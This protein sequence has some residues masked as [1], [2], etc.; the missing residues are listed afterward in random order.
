[1][2]VRDTQGRVLRFNYLD[3]K[4]AQK[5]DRFRGLQSID[6][7]VGRF[8]Y[9]YGSAMPKGATIDPIH[10]LATLVKVSLPTHYD[11]NQPAHPYANRG[12][13]SSSISRTYHYEDANHPT[14]LTGIS[15]TGQGSD[16]QLIH[17]RISTYGYDINGNAILSMK[18]NGAEKVTLDRSEGGKTILTNSLGQKTTYKYAI[19]AGEYRLLEAIGPGCTSCSPGNRR[20][21]YDKLGQLIEEVTLNAAGQTLQTIKTERGKY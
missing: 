18:A 3:Q 13:S 14:L 20:Y 10:L 12:V 21:S 2:S 8:N 19:I 16:Q 6:S 11:A 5:G 15:V 9:S 17:Q 7:P 4:N 1:M